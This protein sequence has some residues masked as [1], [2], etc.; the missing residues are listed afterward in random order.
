MLLRH[1]GDHEEEKANQLVGAHS[2][3]VARAGNQSQPGRA[4]DR[5]SFGLT[6]LP[7]LPVV[8]GMGAQAFAAAQLGMQLSARITERYLEAAERLAGIV[9]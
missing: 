1:D 8:I 7:P 4:G 9:L 2:V 3:C 6:R 5:L